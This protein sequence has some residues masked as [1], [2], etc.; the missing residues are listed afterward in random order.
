MQEAR[1]VFSRSLA[2]RPKSGF[3]AA[4]A[5]KRHEASNVQPRLHEPTIDRRVY[6]RSVGA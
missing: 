1:A 5:K 4:G 6:P 2:E 3:A